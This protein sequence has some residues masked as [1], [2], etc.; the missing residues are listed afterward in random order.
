MRA[1][2]RI[3]LIAG[4]AL[5]L[6]LFSRAAARAA[7]ASTAC[8]K[9]I[10]DFGDAPEGVAIPY[11]YYP[12]GHNDA[13]GHFPSCLAPGAPGT[14]ESFC[15]PISTPPGPTGYVRHLQSGAAN[16]WIGCYQGT[17][18]LYGIDSE[19]DAKVWPLGGTTSAC[20]P[21]V[22]LDGTGGDEDVYGDGDAGLIND[23]RICGSAPI[24]FTTANCG[25]ARSAYLN[26]LVDVNQDGDWNDNI[27]F[28]APYWCIGPASSCLQ[29][30]QIKDFVLQIPSGCATH[31]WGEVPP[32]AVP[33]IGYYWVRLT[34]TDDPV[35]DDFPWAGSATMPGGYFNGGETEDYLLMFDSA[36]PVKTSTWGSIKVLYR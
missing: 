2:I 27:A 36:D 28:S 15:A 25:P 3:L 22:T 9:P 10:E 20:S 13:V 23:Y 7:D 18:G 4:A 11:Y 12:S 19:S 33:N 21:A 34:L 35:N 26:V 8:G 24:T 17:G 16:Y 6:L 32:I 1:L 29:E 31:S 30:W 14:Q 5:A